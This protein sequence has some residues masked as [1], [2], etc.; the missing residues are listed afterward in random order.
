MTSQS[1]RS[2]A[3]RILTLMSLLALVSCGGS[4]NSSNA[5]N[6][7]IS[8]IQHF[9]SPAPSISGN[10]AK[11]SGPR[12]N[13]TISRNSDG[14]TV[15]DQSGNDGT[16]TLPPGT[17]SLTFQDVSVNLL[18]ANQAARMSAIDI[19]SLVELYIA[20]F[21]RVPDAN[22]LS[23]W[24][25][26]L[27]N[28]TKLSDIS[29]SFYLS[30]INSG[31]QNGYPEK[32]STADFVSLIYNNVLNRPVPDKGGLDYWSNALDTNALSKGQFVIQMIA[33]A[34]G[35]ASNPAY[36][37][38]AS[39]L[40][41]KVLV[42][43]NFAIQQGLNYVSPEDATNKAKALLA[44][45]TPADNGVANIL[46]LSLVGFSPVTTDAVT[47][48][49]ASRMLAQATFG[50]NSADITTLAA[51]G[52]KPWLDAQFAKSQKLHR[53]YMDTISTTFLNGLKD[54]NQN[55]FFE[56]FWQQAINGDDQL[57]QRLAFALSQIF[58]I[59]FQDSTVN[60]YPRGVASYYDVLET[61]AF[62]NYRNL[63]EA[64]TLHPMMGIYLT[65]LR[66]QKESATQVPDENYAREVMQLFSIGLYQLN[67]DGSYVLNNGKPVET[68]SSADI[69]GL[70]KVFTGWSWAGPDK[71]DTR[72]FGGNPDANRDWTP[73]QSY[74]KY[75]STS[76]KTFL[77]KTIPAQSSSNPEADLKIALDTLFNHPN[78]APFI[79][80]QLI[81]RL[82]TSNPSPQYVS[83]VA[84]AFINNGQGV[85]GDMKA[86][87]TAILMDSEARSDNTIQSAGSGK[88][89][90]PVI[91]LANWMRAFNV[92]ST[93]GRFLMTSTDDPLTALGQTQMRSPTVFNFYRPGYV[94][95]NTSIA[96]AGLVSPEMQ[97]TG[98]TS[99]VGY[100]N[101][102]RDI[103]PNGTGSAR[104][105]K[106]DYTNLIALAAT[107]DKL[108]DQINLLLM[109]N[110]MSTNLRSQIMSAVN[111]ISI[112]GNSAANADAAKKN[113]V[114]LS[115]FLTMASPEYLVQK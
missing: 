2:Y 92:Q 20:Y 3:K 46:I 86:V 91:R 114:Y 42:S 45:V 99:V 106:A 30:A 110:Q 4:G 10:S 14:I 28:G 59:S 12:S 32:M 80:K 58:V 33:A 1:L 79:S 70:A 88:L 113:R 115:I 109:A 38:V 41:N 52:Y 72:F 26:Q 74:P 73:M 23:Y 104:D 75:H 24:M 94:P 50:A 95:P 89:R 5:G 96:N 39:L 101:F 17:E 49:Q 54:L 36:T 7:L 6:T 100:L 60:N 40:S 21:N 87:V 19:N 76:E 102:M 55:H 34:H 108:I 43:T 82:V 77:G 48:T 63:L 71:S 35:Y 62:G 83:R 27:A 78:V 44:A 16:T 61:N 97:I 53:T 103:I 107:P 8:D 11:F 13:Y 65:S 64:V 68:Y 15:I 105:I 9:F 51:S 90:E 81:Q 84:A 98:E 69:A 66:N 47:S 85:R 22:G 37:D 31:A 111:S 67:Q 25:T 56:S 112:P 57:R 93:S 18:I 29:Q